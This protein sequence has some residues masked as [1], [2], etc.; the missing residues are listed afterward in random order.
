MAAEESSILIIGAGTFGTSTAYHLSRQYK[1]PSLITIIDSS[2]SP[3]KPAASI[4]INRIIRTD[5]PDPLYCDLASEAIHPWF[6]QL[7]LQAHFHKTGW[8][9]MDEKGSDLAKRIRAVLEERGSTQT[10]TISEKVIDERWPFLKNTSK[11]GFGDFYWNPEAS[12]CDAARATASLMAAAEKRRVR[13]VTAKVSKLL[14]DAQEAGIEGVRTVDGNVYRADKVLLA[15]GAWTSSLLSSIEDQLSIPSHDRIERQITATGTVSAYY[16]LTGAEYKRLSGA[17]M[18]MVV[19]GSQGEVIPPSPVSGAAYLKLNN[20]WTTF[21]N[22]VNTSSGHQISVPP[23]TQSQNDVPAGLKRETEKDLISKLLPDVTQGK[24]AEFWRICWDAVS[25]SEDF[26]IC[27]H[28]HPK[29]K[30]LFVATGGS[31]HGYKFLPTIGRYVV[32]VL[33]GESNGEAIDKAFAW[34]TGSGKGGGEGRGFGKLG[35]KMGAKRELR[36]FD[37]GGRANL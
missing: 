14:L 5:Y 26:L 15:V 35:L 3:P 16:R 17:N 27:R 6:W 8:I 18:P 29:L 22:T 36:D 4:D 10:D 32:N 20:S 2:S 12:W 31:F 7:E 34:K 24:K 11:V 33:E 13:R 37:Q 30:K 21:T 19:Y 1:D 25:P 28:P 9:M 23:S